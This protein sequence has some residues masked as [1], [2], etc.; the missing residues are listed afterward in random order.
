MWELTSLIAF[1]RLGL[2]PPRKVD[3]KCVPPALDLAA[4]S[5]EEARK[6]KRKFRKL[7]RRSLARDYREFEKAP[8][9][10]KNDWRWTGCSVRGRWRALEDPL[11]GLLL[12]AKALEVGCRPSQS[13]RG[14]R[15][16]RVIHSQEFQK[17]RMKVAAELG[18]LHPKRSM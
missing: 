7:W 10:R 13:A 6:A 15:W 14:Y 1:E 18:L 5:P 17:M 4:M 9:R 16:G 3:D 11:D 12:F 2:V 8:K